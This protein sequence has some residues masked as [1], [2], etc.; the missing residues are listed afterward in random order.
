MKVWDSFIFFNE[1]DLLEI[2]LNELRD[3]VDHF[4]LV[5]SPFTHSGKPKPLFFQENRERFKDFPIIHVVVEDFPTTPDYWAAIRHPKNPMDWTRENHQRD[6]I[7]RGLSE[8]EPDDMVMLSDLDEIPR[9]SSV[10]QAKQRLQAGAPF[11]IFQQRL[12]YYYMDLLEEEAH[13]MLVTRATL[14]KDF[15]KPMELRWMLQGEML[16]QAGWHFSWLGGPER[17]IEK[18]ESFA[19]QELNKP[20]LKDPSFIETC[21]SMGRTIH[22]MK[23]LTRVPIDDTYPRYLLEQLKHGRFRE[24]VSP[25]GLRQ[26]PWA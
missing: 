1:L 9:A 11:L 7:L 13:P 3:V 8:A 17:I 25:E 12:F 6:S 10:L 22:S 26:L 14:R 20:T 2:R 16:K 15:Q 23:N 24:F 4:V 19:H 18:L 5:E 21:L